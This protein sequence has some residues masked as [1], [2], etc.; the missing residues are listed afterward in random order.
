MPSYDASH[1][2]PPAPAAQVTLR[3]PQ[4]GATVSNV[5]MLLDSGADVTLLPRSAVERLGISLAAGQQSELTG[6]DGS[7][8][9]APVAI[10]DMIFLGR[11]FRGPYVLVEEECG[12]PGR[13]A[14]NQVTLLLDGPRQQ[15]SEHS[16]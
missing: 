2:D 9:T 16:P 5:L 15:W 11:A 6:F 3:D 7:T 1:F 12:I 10:L 4:S 13:N 8:S 14:L